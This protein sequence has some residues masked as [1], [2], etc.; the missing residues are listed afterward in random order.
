MKTRSRTRVVVSTRSNPMRSLL[1]TGIRA[2]LNHA[3]GF[4]IKELRVRLGANPSIKHLLVCQGK[5]FEAKVD[6]TLVWKIEYFVNSL[7]ATDF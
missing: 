6:V 2:A 7:T 1:V 3:Q 4:S 5:E